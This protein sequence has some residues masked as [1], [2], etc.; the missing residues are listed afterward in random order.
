MTRADTLLARVSLLSPDNNITGLS[1]V[2]S[3]PPSCFS[4]LII[5][6]KL[7]KRDCLL[8]SAFNEQKNWRIEIW[9]VIEMDFLQMVSCS[10]MRFTI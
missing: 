7:P 5:S 3:P 9:R 10:R 2:K 4:V 8:N 1:G 6:F